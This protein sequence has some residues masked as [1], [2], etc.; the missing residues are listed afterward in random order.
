MMLQSATRPR[1]RRRLVALV[2]EDEAALMDALQGR[3][4]GLRALPYDYW[5]IALPGKKRQRKRKPS[6]LQ[7]EYLE[8]TADWDRAV[9]LRFWL[10]PA[11]WTPEWAGPNRN[12]IYYVSNAPHMQFRYVRQVPCYER[13][14]NVREGN[15]DGFYEDGDREKLSFL[16]AVMRI[17]GKLSSNIVDVYDNETR[18]LRW[19]ALRTILWVGDHAADWCRGH[20]D[21]WIDG[22]LRPP[23]G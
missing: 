19:P 4:A 5:N 15:I 20:T 17:V 8:N 23:D 3:F 13:N 9:Q 11:G 16:N 1:F 12:G 10:E 22:N 6:E 21:R 7:L 2:K 18:A 14:R